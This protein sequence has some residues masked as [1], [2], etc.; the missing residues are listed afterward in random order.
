MPHFSPKEVEGLDPNLVQ[1][2]ER[3]RGFAGVPFIITE[4]VGSGGH[5]VINSAHQRGLAVDI[6]CSGSHDRMKVV[7]A[8]LI[9]GFKRI[10]VYDKHVHL[11]VD[12]SLPQDVMWTGVSS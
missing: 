3:A 6:R 2:L 8:A 1:M 5:H 10:G 4:G 9:T 11:D 12:P 7:S